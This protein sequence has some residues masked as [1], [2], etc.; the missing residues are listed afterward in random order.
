MTGLRSQRSMKKGSTPN[1]VCSELRLFSREA[2]S[3]K[4]PEAGSTSEIEILQQLR[5]LLI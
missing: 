4:T 1:P 2:I 3:L 5:T